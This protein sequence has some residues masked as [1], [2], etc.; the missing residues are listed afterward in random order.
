[1]GGGHQHD[2]SQ[3][4]QRRSG[5]DL[6]TAPQGHGEARGWEALAASP[7]PSL[8]EERQHREPGQPWGRDRGGAPSKHLMG[9]FSR[10]SKN[11]HRGKCT[12]CRH[13]MTGTPCPQGRLCNCCHFHHGLEA[14]LGR[15]P[16]AL[17]RKQGEHDSA[18]GSMPLLERVQP[19]RL[20]ACASLDLSAQLASLAS[21]GASQRAPAPA[22]SP[23]EEA[24]K[25]SPPPPPCAP[26]A[27]PWG[28]L[29]PEQLA[30]LLREAAPEHYED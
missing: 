2:G 17:L 1:M 11:H 28:R 4:Q 12:P 23:A 6:L 14:L 13:T 5:G 22:R 25:A 10:G 15:K 19:C 20:L 24:A 8:P 26:S 29:R 9:A 30:A 27:A 7:P 16:R 21:P 18:A 3:Q